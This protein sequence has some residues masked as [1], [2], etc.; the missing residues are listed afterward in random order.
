MGH[1][2]WSRAVAEQRSVPMK[3]A[4]TDTSQTSPKIICHSQENHFNICTLTAV[5]GQATKRERTRK[6]EEL[7]TRHSP[8]SV[9]LPHSL[10]DQRRGE[11]CGFSGLQSALPSNKTRKPPQRHSWINQLHQ[12]P[13]CHLEHFICQRIG[14]FIVGIIQSG[15]RIS[16]P[17]KQDLQEGTDSSEIY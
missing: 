3:P 16:P 15:G 10:T 6:G 7:L 13:A 11:E 5:K 17:V 1:S 2:V 14:E 12:A 4:Q 9:C 8:G